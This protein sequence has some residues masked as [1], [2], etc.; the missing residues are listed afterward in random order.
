MILTPEQ[1]EL[2]YA[3]LPEGSWR[4][5][6]ENIAETLVAYVDIVERV[7]AIQWSVEDDFCPFCDEDFVPR[8]RLFDHR[9]DCLYLT[10][11]KLRGLE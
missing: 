10:A 6:C 1:I 4:P 8:E 3:E 5:C 9:P 11:R 7:A 2:I